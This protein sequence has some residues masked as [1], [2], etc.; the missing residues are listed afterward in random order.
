MLL[1]VHARSGRGTPPTNTVLRGS[2]AIEPSRTKSAS[3]RRH[4]RIW[5]GLS[6]MVGEDTH[7]YNLSSSVM[8]DSINCWTL[9]SSCDKGI[10]II[11]NYY[12]YFIDERGQRE[13]KRPLTWNRRKAYPLGGKYDLDSALCG[14]STTNGPKRRN[15][16][17]ISSGVYRGKGDK[18]SR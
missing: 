17:V 18:Y 10:G 13:W 1:H 3:D 8:H 15:E 2:R 4:G 5:T 6:L 16:A 7:R 14:Q 9:L 12:Y 11:A